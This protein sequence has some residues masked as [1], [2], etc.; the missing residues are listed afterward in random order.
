M[1]GNWRFT[2]IPISASSRTLGTTSLR[3]AR[4]HIYD[5]RT[6][7]CVAFPFPKFFNLGENEE[8]LPEKFPWHEP[9]EIYEKMDGWLG[10]LYRHEGRFKIASRGSFHSTGAVWAST[11]LQAFD[12]SVLP[13]EA[14]LVFEIIHP[15]HKI[16][17]NYEGREM[18]IVLAAFNRRTG[19]EYPRAPRR[20][21]GERD[22]LAGRAAA[23]ANVTRGFAFHPE[24]TRELRGLRHSL[25]GRP[26][27]EGK[28]RVVPEHGPHHVEPHRHRPVGSDGGRQ[29]ASGLPGADSG[30][31]ASVGGT[32]SGGPGRPVRL[33]LLQIERVAAPIVR[34]LGHDRR[35]LAHYLDERKKELGYLKSAVFM[36]LDGKHSHLER[37]IMDRIYPKGNQFAADGL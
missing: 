15:E 37:L 26:S 18:L 32:L 36:L 24:E 20:G 30:G 22:R 28:D 10:V 21:L 33:A 2:L 7:E 1:M 13:E 19:E 5:T 9:Y 17:L 6:G 3:N 34:D 16:I 8:N 31:V 35:A 12:L 27:G 4:G 11:H 25:P 23:G 29:S 14:T